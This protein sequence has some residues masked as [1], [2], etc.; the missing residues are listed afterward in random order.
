MRQSP[1]SSE[2]SSRSSQGGV[3]DAAAAAGWSGM[4]EK[5]CSGDDVTDDEEPSSWT[6][7]LASSASCLVVVSSCLAHNQSRK[8]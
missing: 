1:R 8:A 2:R 4:L 3:G 6:I 7:S 5:F